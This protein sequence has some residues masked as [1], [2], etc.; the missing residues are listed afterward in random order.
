MRVEI[1][2]TTKLI[3]INIVKEYIHLNK[4]YFKIHQIA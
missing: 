2:S 1:F 3:H 4:L